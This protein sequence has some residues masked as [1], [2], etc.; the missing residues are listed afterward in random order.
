MTFALFPTVIVGSIW[1]GCRP[2]TTATHQTSRP[3]PAQCSFCRVRP[4]RGAGRALQRRQ[5]PV[6]AGRPL[7]RAA[8]GATAR[9]PRH[10][11]DAR[12]RRLRRRLVGRSTGQE[13]WA[14]AS[15]RGPTVIPSPS[16]ATHG[17]CRPS[18]RLPRRSWRCTAPA[19][20]T[21]STPRSGLLR[22]R[23]TP[24]RILARSPCPR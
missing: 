15:S 3:A 16:A 22:C 1:C 18:K 14:T 20:A 23:S 4:I 8:L 24:I 5:R 19:D 2:E 10:I 6:S 12:A 11:P 21:P 9:H 7:R 17:A 13:P